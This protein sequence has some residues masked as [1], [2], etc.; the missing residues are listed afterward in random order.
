MLPKDV[1]TTSSPF[2]TF[3]EARDAANAVVPFKTTIA[4][5][6]RLGFDIEASRNVTVIPYPELVA[7][8]APNPNVSM[9]E[10]DP[11]IRECIL[12]QKACLAYEFDLGVQ[13][14]R[15]IGGFW[16]D[17]LN[18]RRETHV[19]GWRM[20]ALVAARA[21]VV[22]F[23]NYGGEPYIDQTELRVNPLGPFQPAGEGVGAILVR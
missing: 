6:K 4:D 1:H 11:G 17:F 5:L 14:R 15:R 12:A 23:C 9:H 19:G 8:L 20:R 16:A 7:R 21:G 18:F 2:K 3:E 13:Q 10:L 22:L